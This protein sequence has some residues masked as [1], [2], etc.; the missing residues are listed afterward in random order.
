LETS[1]NYLVAIF[2][3]DVANAKSNIA[4]TAK[5][6]KINNFCTFEYTKFNE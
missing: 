6:L 5:P 3:A 4:K 2:I 1:D